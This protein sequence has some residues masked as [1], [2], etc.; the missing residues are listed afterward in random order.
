MV[1]LGRVTETRDQIPF[2]RNCLKDRDRRV[3]LLA[4]E[5]LA[6]LESADLIALKPEIESLLSDP[7]MPVK[8][9]AMRALKRIG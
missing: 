4:L 8:Q 6:Q 3:R 2:Y 7:Q 5:R 9:A 1:L